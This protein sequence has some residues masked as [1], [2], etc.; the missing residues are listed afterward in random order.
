MKVRRLEREYAW[1]CRIQSIY[2][3]GLNSK[4][5][6]I[7][8][9]NRSNGLSSYNIFEFGR[10]YDNMIKRRKQKNNP[11]CRHRFSDDDV[12]LGFLSIELPNTPIQD[13]LHLVHNRSKKFLRKCIKN[14]EYNR[15]ISFKRK[16]IE[17]RIDFKQQYQNPKLKKN[18]MKGRMRFEINFI[19]KSIQN[20]NLRSILGDRTVKAT[21]PSGCRFIKMPIFYYKYQQNI[22]QKIFNYNKATRETDFTDMNGISALP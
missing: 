22:S 4:A 9:V 8:I 7:G 20:I 17:D 15:I 1:T 2:P 6:T 12:V 19:H 10:N 21:I 18:D 3:F 11:L 14:D 5:K 13:C 16:I